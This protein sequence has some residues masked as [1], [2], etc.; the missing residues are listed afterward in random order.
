LSSRQLVLLGEICHHTSYCS[1]PAYGY[2][3]LCAMLRGP[4]FDRNVNICSHHV[5]IMS[6]VQDGLLA[7]SSVCVRGQNV[8]VHNEGLS[9]KCCQSLRGHTS[10]ALVALS[11]HPSGRSAWLLIRLA[12]GRQVTTA[13]H[14]RPHYPCTQMQ[15][16]HHARE[17]SLHDSPRMHLSGCLTGCPTCMVVA[18]SLATLSGTQCHHL[19]DLLLK[20]Q[21]PSPSPTY[22][23]LPAILPMTR[24]TQRWQC[25]VQIAQ[26]HT[27]M[28]YPPP[29]RCRVTS[30]LVPN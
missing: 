11:K 15:T 19:Q 3:V 27:T 18:P 23:Y 6:H 20:S 30:C 22:C 8:P 10:S 9:V 7:V 17:L 2:G 21:A 1:R 29:L 25:P 26:L 24:P 4:E 14:Q 12:A 13:G 5:P 16:V 28:P